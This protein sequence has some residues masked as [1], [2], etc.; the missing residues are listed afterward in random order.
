MTK[1]EIKE[2]VAKWAVILKLSEWEI[3]VTF[4]SDSSSSNSAEALF[5]EDYDYIHILFSKKY[6]KWSKSYAEEAVIHELM[7]A[8]L[9]HFWRAALE[10]QDE[11][12]ATARELY[13]KRLRHELEN[14][15]ENL[16]QAMK[17]C[18][19]KKL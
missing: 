13:K 10:A 7:H 16:T 8:H 9:Q 5:T 18:Y 1:K 2:L 11:L 6:K 19:A 14:T 4:D 3:K 12:G 15:T 17:G